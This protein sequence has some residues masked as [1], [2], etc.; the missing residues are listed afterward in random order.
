MSP[1]FPLDVAVRQT[2]EDLSRIT[3]DLDAPASAP[4]EGDDIRVGELVADTF[5]I[6]GVL[7]SG[8]MGTVYLAR[9]ETLG[10]DVAVKLIHSDML[11][12]AG[13]REAFVQ[14]AR[15]MARV[16]HPNVVTIHTFG[17]HREQPYL[18]MEHVTGWSLAL[19]MKR[20]GTPDLPE[21]IA[22]LDALCRGVQAIHDAGA[23]HRDLKPANVLVDRAGRVA[24]TD[25]G[26]AGPTEG[27]ATDGARFALGT[28]AYMAP[29]LAREE[30]IDPELAS[31][32]DVYALGVLAFELL[33][34]RSPFDA[35]TVAAA[36]H[37]HAHTPPPRPS[38]RTPGVPTAFDGPILRALAKSPRNRTPSADALR[39]ELHQAFAGASEFPRG[40]KILTVDDE[41][42]TLVAL[43][44]LLLSMFPGAEVISVSNTETAVEVAR[45]ERPD[46]VVTDFD[47]PGGGGP[48]I[49]EALRSDPATRETPI[50]VMTGRGG[51]LEWQAMRELGANRF[52]VK[53]V[54]MDALAAMIRRLVGDASP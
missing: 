13:M 30:A 53:P 19:R 4:D 14:E 2:I 7:G 33:T 41:P 50:I 35:V 20:N 49:T 54:D 32:I 21:A 38:A 3:V 5:R 47:M 22:I 51:A 25:F 11:A 16:R 29:E 18:V 9:D 26:L 23:L 1:G 44:E 17:V 6:L 8:G 52:L 12:R 27:F 40:L 31:R 37:D 45:R 15:A 39:R 28:P 46:V 42:G 43:R 36:L 48:V 24:V 10:R 34:G